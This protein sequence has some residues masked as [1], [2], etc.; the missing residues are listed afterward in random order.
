MIYRNMKIEDFE[1]VHAL[2]RATEGVQPHP[3]DNNYQTMERY[4]KHNPDTTFV[5]EENGE[6][7][8]IILCGHDGRRGYIYQ[9]AV[10]ESR[11]GNGIGTK[12]VNLGINALRAEGIGR[13]GMFAL[14]DNQRIIDYWEK[15]GFEPKDFM[16]FRLKNL[17]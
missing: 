14:V 2:W 15:M 13:V 6:I 3:V 4:I 10:E 5:A 12:L 11:R 16:T 1:Q 8:G 9:L 17:D 7:I